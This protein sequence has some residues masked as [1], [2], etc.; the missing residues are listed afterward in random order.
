MIGA[1]ESIYPLPPR[2]FG[3]DAH[4]EMIAAFQTNIVCGG[5]EIMDRLIDG[6]R[7]AV[8]RKATFIHIGSGRSA[9]IHCAEWL[10]FRK[11]RI[12]EVAYLNDTGAMRKLL[13]GE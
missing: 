6:D 13:D 3:R 5:N 11:G 7:A 2:C 4:L 12:V 8:M 1:P 9:V 10:R